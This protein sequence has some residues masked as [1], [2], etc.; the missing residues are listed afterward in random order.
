MRLIETPTRGWLLLAALITSGSTAPAQ[1][2]PDAVEFHVKPDGI[3]PFAS[4]DPSVRPQLGKPGKPQWATG[5]IEPGYWLSTDGS[6]ER[7][8]ATLYQAQLAV[9]EFLRAKG[10]PDGGIKV[11]VHGGVYRPAQTLE[12]VPEDS[13]APD[14][15]VVYTAAPGEKPIVS[16]GLPITGW[17]KLTAATPGLPA[18]AVGNVW[19][20]AAPEIGAATL[21]FRQ[22]YVN[23]AKAVRARTPNGDGFHRMVEWDLVNRQAIVDSRDVGEWRNVKRVEMV[24]QQSWVISFLRIE[25]ISVEGPK[26]RITFQ[27]PERDLAFSHPYPWPR[28]TDP[29]FFANALEFLDQ[30]GEWYL[31]YKAGLIYYWPRAGEDMAKARV[32]APRLETLVRIEGSADRP[33]HDIHFQGLSFED[34]TWLRPTQAGL[35]P[36]QAGQYFVQ[37]GYRIK[38]GVPLQ[39]VLDNLGWTARPPAAVYLAG[40]SRIL[41]ERCNFRNTASAALDFHHQSSKNEVVGCV[42]RGIGGNGVQIGRFSEQG[43]EA[44]LPYRVADERELSLNDRVANSYFRDCG[45]EDWGSTAIAAGYP[46]GLTIEHNEIVAMP[47]SGI[48]MGWGWMAQENAMRDNKI[49][50][51]RI[52]QYMERMGDGG[53]IYVLSN[54]TPSEIRGNYIFDLR[55][56]PVGDPSAM[57]YLDEGSSGFLVKDNLTETNVFFKNR[58]GEGNR[59]ENTGAEG[60]PILKGPPGSAGAAGLET[61]FLD[62]LQ[63]ADYGVK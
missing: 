56:S 27:E 5:G 18:A 54:Q 21:D 55:H 44:H 42:F 58:N 61:A 45:N 7:P 24:P 14:K 28:N 8:F 34:S 11:V 25:S 48:S 19:V 60:P 31:D 17:R 22:L 35:V 49:L 29:Y 50:Y 16:G 10:M 41:F 13:G 63:S 1:G 9:R 33:V 59:W 37:P 57:I 47:Y 52:H 15:P 46:R 4:S 40:A 23:G 43:L 36:L 38:G 26:A 53:G 32:V 51:N 12:F 2:A 6:A 20:A 30:P 62:L 39:P 3:Q